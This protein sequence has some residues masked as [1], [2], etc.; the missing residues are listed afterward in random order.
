MGQRMEG[1]RVGRS[2]GLLECGLAQHE[3]VFFQ[4]Q[5]GAGDFADGISEF[6]EVF[7]LELE[8]V[9]DEGGTL[10]HKRVKGLQGGEA[11]TGFLELAGVFGNFV[12]GLSGEFHLVAGKSL[13]SWS[14]RYS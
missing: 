10:T 2:Q 9:C 4:V 7:R 5:L 13:K 8:S 3:A 6:V 14:L 1:K 12:E 11:I